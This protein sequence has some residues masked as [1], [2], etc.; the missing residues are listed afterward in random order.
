MHTVLCYGDSNTWG[1]HPVSGERLAMNERWPGVLRFELGNAYH[2]IEEGL[3][4]RTTTLDDPLGLVDRNGRTYLEPCLRSHAPV[5]LCILM[6]G[7]NDLK[8]HFGFTATDAAA[9]IGV[10][11]EIILRSG[12]GPR[13]R[14]PTILVLAPPPTVA[15]AGESPE[16][17]RAL[18]SSREFGR[19]YRAIA[20]T[21]HCHFMDA[22][23]L[24]S[25]SP[26]D[27]VHLDPPAHRKLGQAVAEEVRK[28]LA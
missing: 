19:Q 1:Y 23:E 28:I 11:I 2:V 22:G 7:T 25:A 8:P 17:S 21:Y 10:L 15:V 3:N 5:D 14:P 27:G 24:V 18:A 26:V 13:M 6:L 12:A 20:D 9:G 16:W 4:G